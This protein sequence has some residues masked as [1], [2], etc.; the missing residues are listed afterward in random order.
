MADPYITLTSPNPENF[1]YSP[2]VKFFLKCVLRMGRTYR[3]Y[4]VAVEHTKIDRFLVFKWQSFINFS[5]KEMSL[6]QGVEYHLQSCYI[7][8]SPN[9][10]S[11]IEFTFL[12][13]VKVFGN[14][15]KIYKGKICCTLIFR[16]NGN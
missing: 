15:F 6:Y 8:F 12:N 13:F 11:V 3:T 4:T 7:F 1:S 9:I 16:S 2:T 14:Q 10:E 5:Q